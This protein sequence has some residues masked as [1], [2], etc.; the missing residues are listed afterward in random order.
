MPLSGYWVNYPSGSGNLKLINRVVIAHIDGNNFLIFNEKLHGDAVGKV[1]RYRV[2]VCKS[3]RQAMQSERW[4][5]GVGLQQLQGLQVLPLQLGMTLEETAGAFLVLRGK[6]QRPTH[7]EALRR[8][9]CSSA[10]SLTS[11]PAATSA[12][13]WA[14]AASS[15]HS[16]R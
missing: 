5:K 3:S 16:R 4:M 7:R 11:R 1:D 15:S 2:Q 13:V 8:D 9:R 12:R 14:R 6:D 10:L